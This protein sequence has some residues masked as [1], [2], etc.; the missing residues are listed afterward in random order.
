M[1]RMEAQAKLNPQD[2][3]GNQRPQ[4]ETQLEK[5]I[6][7]ALARRMV[8]FQGPRLPIVSKRRARSRPPPQR[9]LFLEAAE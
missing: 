4:K 1:A 9:D 2:P 5:I 6:K 3:Q 7:R 8:R